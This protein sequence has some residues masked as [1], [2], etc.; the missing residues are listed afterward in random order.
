MKKKSNRAK[1]H[2]SKDVKKGNTK[3]RKK[4]RAKA[5]EHGNKGLEE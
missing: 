5:M 4:L 1:Y 3:V 2:K